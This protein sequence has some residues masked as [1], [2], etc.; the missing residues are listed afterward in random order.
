MQ[1]ARNIDRNGTTNIRKHTRVLAKVTVLHIFATDDL[2]RWSTQ[3]F[4][5]LTFRLPDGEVDS[6][7]DEFSGSA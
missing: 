2:Y 6:S 5:K 7:A 4:D 3:L 1:I